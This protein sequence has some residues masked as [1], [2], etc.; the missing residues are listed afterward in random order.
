MIMQ[1]LE[2]I[3]TTGT[4][5]TYRTT[6]ER[7]VAELL[8]ELKLEAKFF[9]VLADGKRVGLNDTIGEG[10]GNHNSAENRWWFLNQFFY[11]SSINLYLKRNQSVS[12]QFL[13]L[14]S[15]SNKSVAAIVLGKI[16]CASCSNTLTSS[17][18]EEK[19]VKKSK[20][21]PASAA[22]CAAIR[23]GI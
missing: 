6:T 4:L 17:L 14:I 21:T 12:D 20:P 23:E 18:R 5:K 13:G 2:E 10:S 9:A 3:T 7:T 8:K 19:C 11:N 22:S 1:F 16:F 15:Y